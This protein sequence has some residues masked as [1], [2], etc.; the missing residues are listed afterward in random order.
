MAKG[1]MFIFEKVMVLFCG[2][3][4]GAGGGREIR[5]KN[6]TSLQKVVSSFPH[7]QI[8]NWQ[9]AYPDL[10]LGLI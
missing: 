3:M 9:Q 5:F 10:S 6:L 4:E 8:Q 7:K 2:C 1:C